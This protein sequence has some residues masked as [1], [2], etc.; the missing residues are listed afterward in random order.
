MIPSSEERSR[1]YAVISIELAAQGRADEATAVLA[2]QVSAARWRDFA[3]AL[4]ARGGGSGQEGLRPAS[5]RAGARAIEPSPSSVELSISAVLESI[6]DL[7]VLVS[8]RDALRS[9]DMAALRMRADLLWRLPVGEGALLT[10]LLA[11]QP[12]PNLLEKLAKLAPLLALSSPEAVIGTV[13]A[14]GA[15]AR[16][17]R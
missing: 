15:C 4:I 5:A 16:A 9:R 6:G 10:E 7:P 3:H 8:M 14:I 2:M 17:W 11:S 13:R 12:R 1:A